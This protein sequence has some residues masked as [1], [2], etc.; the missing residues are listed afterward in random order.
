VPP[1]RELRSI[2]EGTAL[3]T[4]E[5][6]VLDAIRAARARIS[7]SALR[8]PLLRLNVDDAP[9]EIWLKLENLQPIGSFKLRGAGNAMGLLRREQLARGVYTASAGNMAQGVAWNARRLGVPCTVVVPDHAP[10]TKLAAIERLG[11]TIVPLPFDDWWKVIVEHHHP[12]V[13]GVFIHPVSDS[14]V[15]AGNGTI[16]LEILEDLPDVTAVLVPYG[17]GGL[18]CGIASA[19]RATTPGV[20]V[21]GCEVETATP[22]TAALAAGQPTPVD[23]TASFV[24]GI[25]SRRVLEEMWPLV[26]QLL[27]GAT[28]VSLA[29]T[30]A[31][32]KLMVERNRVVAEG[33]GATPVAAALAGKAGTGKIVCVV[34]GGNIDA[35]KLAAI[36]LGEV[37]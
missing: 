17:G 24:D 25:G 32:V 15:M 19:I 37:P 34:S 18:S 10:Q 21:L 6:P 30:A 26:S 29:E 4:I 16:G 14:A 2:S 27:D 7:G 3:R 13:E 12:G 1:A 5:A 11:A 36:L 20:K 8:T 31:A 23:Y 28:V 35:K 22:L 33:A 9:A